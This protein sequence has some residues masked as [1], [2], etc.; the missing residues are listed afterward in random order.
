MTLT[1][2]IDRDWLTVKEANNVGEIHVVVDDDFTVVLDESE[3]YEQDQVRW[4]HVLSDPDRLPHRKYIF[5]YQLCRQPNKLA[6]KIPP[7]HSLTYLPTNVDSNNMVLHLTVSVEFL[8]IQLYSPFLVE[9]KKQQEN[10]HAHT[11]TH[12]HTE[13]LTIIHKRT[14]HYTNM[15]KYL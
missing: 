11:H 9:K 1:K 13:H 5:I 15:P 3:C 6:I 14:Q 4:A 8:Y 10:P 2:P 12:T 7:T